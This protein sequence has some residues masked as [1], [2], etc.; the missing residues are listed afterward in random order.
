MMRVLV[1]HSGN[2]YGGL[3]RALDTFAQAPRL[4]VDIEP[5]FALCF[6]GA[7][8]ESLRRAGA[9]PR[10]LGRV[11]ITRPDLVL[12]ARRRL[13]AILEETRPDVVVTPAPW[14]HA[15]FAP[16]VR[17]ARLPLVFWLH[18]VLSGRSWIER[19]AGLH[20]P[21][22]M[23]ANS[24][25]SLQH[26]RTVF[27][28]V[29]AQV[30]YYPLIFADP[31]G[32]RTAVRRAQQTDDNAVVIANVARMERFKGQ[33]VLIDALARLRENTAWVC[34]MIGGAQSVA[35]TEYQRG[36]VRQV[37]ERGLSDRVRFLGHRTDVADLLGAADM[38]CH[39]NDS[40]E[41]FGIAVVEALHAGLPVIASSTGGPAEILTERCGRAVPPGDVAGLA[42]A[43]RHYIEDGDDRRRMG[44]AGQARATEL[45]DAS[46][47]LTEFA[48][49]LEQVR[50]RKA[51]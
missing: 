50:V 2:M 21:D 12:R 27:P 36:L 39:P 25:F 30:I 10:T 34:W 4:G 29:P 6:D 3:E 16:V 1:V 23:I 45:C 31:A 22:L 5:Q 35:E 51:A 42:H 41:A 33:P 32:Q 14:T 13:A 26:A 8:A 9:A 20:Q 24:H 49:A 38:Y 48:L 17:R 40:G 7:A 19:I 46:A 18:D 37:A 11:R 15:V 43:L 44:S 47:R 28:V